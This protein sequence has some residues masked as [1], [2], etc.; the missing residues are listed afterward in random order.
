MWPDAT[1]SGFNWLSQERVIKIVPRNQTHSKT[2]AS[3]VLEQSGNN[4]NIKEYNQENKL[5]GYND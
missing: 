4:T 3:E 5:R 1:A 2:Y